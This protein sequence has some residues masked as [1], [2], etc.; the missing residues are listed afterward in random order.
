MKSLGKKQLKE[1]I[2]KCWMSHDGLWFYHSLQESGIEKT[3][4]INQAAARS[5]GAV[6]AKRIVRA[7]DIEKVDTFEKLKEV[8][9][10]GFDVVRGGFMDFDFDCSTKNVMH[11]TANRCFAYEGIKKMGAI[12]GYDCGIFARVAGWFDGLEI[13]YEVSPQIEGCM[14]HA[15]GKCSR[16]FRFFF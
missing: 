12:D 10:D 9:D 14:M 5:I 1:L 2:V 11:I 4:R 15:E 16:D 13:K 7:L 6:E 8:I 3:S